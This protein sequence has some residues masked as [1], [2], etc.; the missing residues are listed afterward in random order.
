LASKES[1]ISKR[2]ERKK[3]KKKK[4]KEEDVGGEGEDITAQE[5]GAH[6]LVLV[7]DWCSSLGQERHHCCGRT[8]FMSYTCMHNVRCIQQVC[9]IFLYSIHTE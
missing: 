5:G 4:K 1:S 2:K 3:K 7:E 9:T 6:T 8:V